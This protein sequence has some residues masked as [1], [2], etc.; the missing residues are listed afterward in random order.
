MDRP[1][2]ENSFEDY[3]CQYEG[4]SRT[5]KS[6]FSLKRH[7][8]SHQGI[9]NHRC[10]YCNKGFAL[11][12]Y[13]REHIHIHTGEKPFVCN[14]PGCG[15][16]FRQAG[17]LS[18][19]KKEHSGGGSP[20][21]RSEFAASSDED[22]E[23]LQAVEAVF[24]QLKNF[25]IPSFLYSKVLP[26]PQQIKEQPVI[27]RELQSAYEKFKTKTLVSVPLPHGFYGQLNRYQL[28]KS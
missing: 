2:L 15:K 9:R 26:L 10:P 11:A 12:Q 8:L 22:T 17:K 23:N 6:K 28:V 7:Y 21:S 24:E 16:Q 3:P 27:I 1:K 19:H 5:Y 4:C 18:I 20:D 13:L 14:Y 25:T